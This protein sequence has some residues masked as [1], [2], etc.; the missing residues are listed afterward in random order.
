MSLG[1]QGAQ[2]QREM[3]LALKLYSTV[4][5]RETRV[6][7]RRLES[8]EVAG[9]DRHEALLLSQILLLKKQSLKLPREEQQTSCPQGP[10][11]NPLFWDRD[12]SKTLCPWGKNRKL[13]QLQDGELAPSRNRLQLE[14][15]VFDSL[16]CGNKVP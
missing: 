6:T 4:C 15:S 8:P 1:K 9:G 2:T 12:G 7:G 13:P 5:S 11:I 10:D 16:G 3:V 14:E